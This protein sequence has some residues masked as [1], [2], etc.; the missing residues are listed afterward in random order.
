[1]KKL[2][3]VGLVLSLA[4][5]ASAAFVLDYDGS[6]LNVAIDGG[7]LTGYDLLVEV[8]AGDGALAEPTVK[9]VG[10]GAWAA[11]TVQLNLPTSVRVSAGAIEA[12]GGQPIPGPATILSMPLAGSAFTVNVSSASAAGTILDGQTVPQGLIESITVPVPE[13]MTMSLLALGG[14]ALLRRRK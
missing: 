8:V 5:M 9:A 4:S 11:P 1:M 14:M 12:F 6:A 3:A 7:S 13:P 2:L 10:S